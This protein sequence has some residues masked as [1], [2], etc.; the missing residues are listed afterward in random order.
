ML[1]FVRYSKGD[2][3][4]AR[5]RIEGMNVPLVPAGSRGTIVSTTVLGRPKRV[6]FVVSDGW[7]RKR[8]HVDVRF[9]DIGP[10]PDA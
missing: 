1:R 3:V 4:I 9:G 7:G 6:F 5:R 8:F 2:T 10:L